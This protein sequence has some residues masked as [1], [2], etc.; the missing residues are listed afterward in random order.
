ME[1]QVT[2]L[3]H[4]KSDAGKNVNRKIWLEKVAWHRTNL[5]NFTPYRPA[6]GV[7][8]ITMMRSELIN[9]CLQ[10]I[11]RNRIALKVRL[12][13]NGDEGEYTRKICEQWGRRWA[14]DYVHHPRK[15]PA[16]V[17]ND[18]MRWA[19]DNKF[20]YLIFV[21]DDML[22]NQSGLTNLVRSIEDNPEYYAM[23]GVLR[24]AKGI[25][26]R[27][28]GGVLDKDAF[29]NLPKKPGVQEADWVGG[30]FTIHK[31][32]PVVPYDESYQ[33]GFNDFDWSMQVKA[34]GLRLGVTGSASAYH[35]FRLTSKG[36]VKHKNSQEYNA[37]RYDQE[38]H[39]RMREIFRS[40]WN[41]TIGKGGLWTG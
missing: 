31:L 30:G 39:A 11:F 36:L 16:E 34:R 9:Q 14:V 15:W 27:M 25:P 32:D 28:I 7:M 20:K 33:T 19:K 40:K 4:P 1:L 24:G 10:A 17:R 29:W 2:H 41:F 38:R 5:G 23:S 21:D 26:E 8:V 6:V 22:V 13:N 35:G 3:Y 37:V 18:S 12:I